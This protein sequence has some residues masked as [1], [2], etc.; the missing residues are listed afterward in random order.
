MGTASLHAYE[1][2]YYAAF[3]HLVF[4]KIHPSQDGNGRT[5]RLLEK[6]FLIEKMGEK[7]TAV[8]LKKTI[9]KI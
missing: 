7:A 5:A 6:W 2:F 9:I 3:V 4:I 8:Q 1:I